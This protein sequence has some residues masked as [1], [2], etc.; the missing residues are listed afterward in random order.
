L[1][2]H[3]FDAWRPRAVQAHFFDTWL[4][5]EL[6]RRR[7]DLTGAAFDEERERYWA[8]PTA[9]PA[10]PAPH[11][12]GGAVD[13][14]IAWEDGEPLFMG[15]LFDDPSVISGTDY[16]ET[17]A[18]NVSTEEARANRRILYWTMIEAGF[19]NHA[20]E[21]WHYCWGDQMWARR[22]GQ[23]AALYGLAAPAP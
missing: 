23:P 20:D 1:R 10:S 19:A 15:S 16:F 4:P 17:R 6:R 8:R 12:T 18:D 7:P 2:L 22:T 11:S 3:V 13:L 5:A 9:D 21:W 14:T